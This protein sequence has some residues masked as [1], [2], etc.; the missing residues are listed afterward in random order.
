MAT[1]ETRQVL[2]ELKTPNV[3]RLSDL[4]T[5]T[6]PGMDTLGRI[7]EQSDRLM[8]RIEAAQI[9]ETDPQLLGWL[10]QL[11]R[12]MRRAKE[13]ADNARD[14]MSRA[15]LALREAQA[16]GRHLFEDAGEPVPDHLET[17]PG[18]NMGPV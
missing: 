12:K 8:R 9:A 5:D 18:R 14:K 3:D 4:R 17:V 16:I 11:H 7:A 10:N 1:D 2:N 15:G 6:A 13:D